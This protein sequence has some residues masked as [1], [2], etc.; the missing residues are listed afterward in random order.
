MGLPATPAAAVDQLVN[1]A[2]VLVSSASGVAWEVCLR[3]WKPVGWP[4]DHAIREPR[5]CVGNIKGRLCF[6]Q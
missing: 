3:E 4:H 2:G 6:M 1:N 5:Q